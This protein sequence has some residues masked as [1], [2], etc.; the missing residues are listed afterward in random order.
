MNDKPTPTPSPRTDWRGVDLRGGRFSETSVEGFDF[1]GAN[2]SGCD[3][4]GC[5]ARYC[6]FRGA[7]VQGANFQGAS[8]YGAKFQG[9]EIQHADFRGCNLQQTD[10]RGAYTEGAMMDRSR[11]PSDIAANPREPGSGQE[12]ESR[13]WR[14]KIANEG[15][16]DA[17]SGNTGNDQSEN[18]QGRV[19]HKEQRQQKS[20][21]DKGGS[22][23]MGD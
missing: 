15:R 3:F 7:N 22:R 4:S 16:P 19:L 21:M 14:T 11:S 8:L 12:Q 1:R 13:Y 17:Q 20:E 2:L 9:A 23:G 18:A 6:D 10:F 5:N